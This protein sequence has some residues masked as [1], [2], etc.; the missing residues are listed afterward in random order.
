MSQPELGWDDEERAL[1]K[2]AELDM[3]S[4][5]AQNR[6]LA[7]LGVSGAVLSTAITAG[8]AK[9]AAVSAGK[10]FGLGKLLAILAI[11]GTAGGAALHYRAH[12][13]AERPAA[14]RASAPAKPAVLMAKATPAPPI[15]P[16]VAPEVDDASATPG[17]PLSPGAAK[18]TPPP[19]RTEP[20]IAL[21][22]A[23]LDRARRASESG[24]F[25]TALAELDQYDRTFKQGRLRP[26]ALLLRIQTLIS[27]GDMAGA[28]ALGG[29]F[30]A[31]Y[32]KSP[33]SP[34][35]QKLIGAT[36]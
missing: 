25:A 20:D 6:T 26:E 31:R 2:S 30:L 21:E 4:T 5:G 18:A 10:G 3:P 16:A 14:A 1:L 23:A 33:L 7:A 22:I 34:R 29:R 17:V 28:K 35:I 8:S 11:G 15:A 27:K 36:P 9:A 19:A 13:S 32:P 12:F 24:S